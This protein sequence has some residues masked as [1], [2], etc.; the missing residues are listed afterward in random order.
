VRLADEVTRRGRPSFALLA[1]WLW[2]APACRAPDPG[3]SERAGDA[4]PGI[5]L[6]DA[7]GRALR[8]PRPA[9]RVVSLVP[10]ATLTLQAL[11]AGALLVARTDHDTASWMAALP[12]VGGGLQPSLE[13]IVAARPDLVIRFA[14]P[15]D[16]RTPAAL[17]GLGIPSLAIRPDRIS[18]VLESVRLLGAATGRAA[19]ADSLA[20]SLRSGLDSVRAAFAGRPTVQVAYVL[21]GE[22]PWVAGPGTY[23]QELLEIAGGRNAFEDLGSLY[24]AVSVEEFLARR[25][26]VILTPDAG[27][28]DPRI[29]AGSRVVAVGGALE[30]PGPGVAAA[31]RLVAL[32]L[33]GGE[34]P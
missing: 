7:D 23:I 27:R 4:A 28:L 15:Q 8:L 14:G 17:D 33:H 9:E 19:A 34:A 3:V 29:A 1:L 2:V 26:E 5:A 12:S 24:A 32:L 31:A 13:A 25:I 10:S 11:G 16:T 18:D 21:G 30:L 22:P 6:T 20:R